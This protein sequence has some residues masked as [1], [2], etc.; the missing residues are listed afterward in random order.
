M[1]KKIDFK[2]VLIILLVIIF[3]TL[4]YF[5]FSSNSENNSDV[6]ESTISETAT[7]S[8]A[9]VENKTIMNTISSSGEI[10]SSLTENI[11]LHATYYFSE[12]YYGENDYVKEGEKI[13]KYTNGT[14]LTAPYNLVITSINIPGTSEQCTN[15]HYI[16]VCA[17]D[18]LTMN[19]QIDEDELSKISVG[20]EAQIKLTVN[21]ENEYTGYVTNISSTATYSGSSSK[22]TVTVEFQNDEKVL[23]GMSGTCSIILEKV[24][25]AIVV[26][27]ESITTTNN[28]SY[29]TVIKENGDTEKVVVTTGISNDAYTEIK[30]GLDG[31][32]KVQIVTE[33]TNSSSGNSKGMMMQQQ[34]GDFSQMK[35]ERMQQKQ[36]SGVAAPTQK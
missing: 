12:M 26:P 3:A 14:Y 19:L 28:Q 29:V 27:K 21:S 4:T 31:N 10:K 6:T 16:T 36:Q 23:V 13:L 25:N 24:D 2:I 20:Q 9:D 15:K 5:Y 30:S 22:F 17:T 1:K 32:E 34:S 8:Q 35:Q 33:E 18:V 7:V 11:E